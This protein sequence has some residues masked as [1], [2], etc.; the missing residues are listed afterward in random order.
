M[1]NY[2]SPPR[3]AITEA[4]VRSLLAGGPQVQV[5]Q[6]CDL[7]DTSNNVVADI[8]A[9]MVEGGEITGDN[10]VTGE[11]IA[12]KCQL[13]FMRELAWG[14][15]RVRPWVSLTADQLVTASTTVIDRASAIASRTDNTTATWGQGTLTNVTAAS[16]ALTLTQSG[17]LTTVTSTQAIPVSSGVTVNSPSNFY[18][19]AT[20]PAGATWTQAPSSTGTSSPAPPYSSKWTYQANAAGAHQ[21][22]FTGASPA[23]VVASGDYLVVWVYPDPANPPTTIQIQT[24]DGTNWYRWHWGGTAPYTS[25]TL[26]SATV[27]PAG[28]WSALVIRTADQIAV[29][30]NITSLAMS[31]Y[32]GAA[33]FDSGIFSTNVQQGN[34]T[35]PASGT[36]VSPALSLSTL[37]AVDS[38]SVSWT[39]TT[40]TG[41]TVKIETSVDGGSTWQVATNGGTISGATSGGS[42]TSRATLTGN[43]SA[44]PTLSTL[45]VSATQSQVS[46]VVT[47]T[48]TQAVSAKWYQGVYVLTTPQQ[49]SGESPVTYDVQGY[50][51]TSILTDQVGDTYV[52]AAGTTYLTA[53][54][55][56]LTASGVGANLLLAGDAGSTALQYT[57]TWG[58]YDGGPSWLQ[59]CA[60]LLESIGY[61]RLWADEVGNLRS[62]PKVA[63]ATAPVSWTFDATDAAA[64]IVAPG[65]TRDE[66]YWSAPNKWTFIQANTKGV[67]PTTANGL[68]YKVTNQSDGASSIDSLGRGRPKYVQLD[69]PD[70]ATLKTQGD[71][72][73]AA[74]KSA[75]TKVNM[76]T[77]FPAAGHGDVVQF[78]S[79]ENGTEKLPVQTWTTNLDGTPGSWVLGAWPVESSTPLSASGAGTVTQASPLRIVMD[80]ANQDSPANSL[81]GTAYAIGARVTVTVRNPIPPLVM[82]VESATA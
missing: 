67:S 27:P 5:S 18:T 26:V 68:V 70:A 13:K 52:V 1:Q 50:D 51:L 72:I 23:H 78:V 75:G 19:A 10:T 30:S 22:Y 35:Y 31:L 36:R 47:S 79:A 62:E 39:A 58:L 42:V 49:P 53:L 21:H 17:S 64:G 43:G 29:G 69:V 15:D 3:D 24:G 32:N 81:D 80:G 54:R 12:G 77:F 9:D 2:T 82:G 76:Q 8:S 60:D 14:K 33:W 61:N 56:V 37:A 45:T 38:S 34:V 71:L 11:S 48:S 74:D 66:D 73:V 4:Q 40:P 63:S 16:N 46:H 41:T 55:N 65:W 28:K 59:I 20:P 57:M 7:L 44:T 25:S 6:G